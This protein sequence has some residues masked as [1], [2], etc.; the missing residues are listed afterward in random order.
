MSVCQVED[1]IQLIRNKFTPVLYSR[2][3]PSQISSDRNDFFH[4]AKSFRQMEDEITDLYAA[5]FRSFEV[6]AGTFQQRQREEFLD[7]RMQQQCPFR[8][9][10]PTQTSWETVPGASLPFIQGF[11][12][13]GYSGKL[14]IPHFPT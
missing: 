4:E 1:V 2:L 12:P 6:W 3:S 5:L 7:L 9:P 13:F 8:P 14:L 10:Q 11:M